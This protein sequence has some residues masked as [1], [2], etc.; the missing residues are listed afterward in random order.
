MK[1][2]KKLVLFDI[3]GTLCNAM[4]T[5]D[6]A[7]VVSL[8]S[9]K[10]AGYDIGIVGGSDRTKAEYQLGTHILED[11]ATHCFHENGAVYYKGKAKVAQESLE[12][13]ID[14][15]VLH[16]VIVFLLRQVSECDSPVTTGTFIERRSAMINCSPCGRACSPSQRL[17]FF[18]W[19]K[20]SGCRE[21]IVNEFHTTFPNLPLEVAIGGQISIDIFPKGFNKTKCLPYVEGI[22][23]EIH[24]VG[25]RVDKGGNDHELYIDTRVIGHKTSGPQETRSIISDIISN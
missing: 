25:D 2:K 17:E 6:D 1:N 16:Q 18:E 20:R 19:D 14:P 21:R 4:A 13:Y 23:D 10:H 8:H 22:Y 7:T 15:V 24:F 12:D 9:L 11:V 5:I 3:D